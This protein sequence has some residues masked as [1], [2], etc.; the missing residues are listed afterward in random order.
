MRYRLVFTPAVNMV[1]KKKMPVWAF[2]YTSKSYELTD[3]VIAS[4][5]LF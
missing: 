5:N 4:T 1:V 3:L 2:F